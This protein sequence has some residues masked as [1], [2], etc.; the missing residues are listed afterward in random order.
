MPLKTHRSREAIGARMEDA[1]PFPR[2]WR[3]VRWYRTSYLTP[4]MNYSSTAPYGMGAD[5]CL[6][7]MGRSLGRYQHDCTCLLGGMR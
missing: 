5:G 3:R 7:P 1:A 6:F 4:D 2:F